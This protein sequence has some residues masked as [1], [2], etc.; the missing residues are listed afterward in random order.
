MSRALESPRGSSSE[1]MISPAMRK[2]GG[3]P[4]TRWMSEASFFIAARMSACISI[5]ISP[6]RA[7]T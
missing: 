1:A 6:G 3:K 5:R 7:N 2:A 4:E